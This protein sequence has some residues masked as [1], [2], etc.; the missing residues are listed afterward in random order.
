MR[1]VVHPDPRGG[2]TGAREQRA[3][4]DD[5][6][7][8]ELGAADAL[9]L[10]DAKEL[11]VVKVAQRLVGQAPQLLAAGGAAAKRRQQRLG[12]RP[13]LSVPID[14]SQ[15]TLLRCKAKRRAAG[16]CSRTGA[17]DSRCGAARR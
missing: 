13:Q 15:G 9:G 7:E 11:G 12:A 3:E 4:G 1:G 16:G 14:T 8:L 17:R 6:G 2:G 10:V 5:G